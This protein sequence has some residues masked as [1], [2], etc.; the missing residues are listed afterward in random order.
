MAASGYSRADR[1]GGAAVRR[2][3][4]LQS[5]AA[6]GG[7]LAVA[8]AVA[9][10]VVKKLGQAMRATSDAFRAQ[11]DAETSLRIAADNNPYLNGE[12]VKRLGEYAKELQ[13]VTELSDNEALDVMSQLTNLC[14]SEE[15]RVGKEC[16]SRWSPYH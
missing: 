9:I 10:G 13:K 5:I 3:L 7:A 6:G 14:R 4:S 1:N 12:G 15:R 8:I 11:N 16:R 2:F